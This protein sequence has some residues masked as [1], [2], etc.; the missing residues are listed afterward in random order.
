MLSMFRLEEKLRICQNVYRY[1]LRS[2][3]LY[4]STKSMADPLIEIQGREE[5][6]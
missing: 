6:K 5:K 1:C 3:M 2:D 4:S